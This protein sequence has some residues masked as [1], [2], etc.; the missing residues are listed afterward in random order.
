MLAY[1]SKPELKTAFLAE[2]AKHEQADRIAH[3]G[4]ATFKQ[5]GKPTFSQGCAV[6]CSLESMRIIEG[7][8]SIEHGN[9]ALYEKYLGVPKALARLEDRLFENLPLAD[10]LTWPRRFSEA[11]R[12]GADLSMAMPRFLLDL[13]S[14][15][16]GA[17]QQRC[18]KNEKIA[19]VVEGVAALYRLWVETGTKPS[20]TQ[21]REA[22][23]RSYA[24]YA[25]AA[26]A[27]VVAAYAYAAADAY[28]AVAAYAATDAAA[29][30]ASADE[31][32]SYA[33]AADARASRSQEVVRQADALIRILE[34]M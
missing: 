21:W 32:A 25:D 10:S 27:Y 16:T 24:A 31:A 6:G 19:A 14:D 23:D 11:I 2:I 12:P 5:N 20:A 13:L 33:S 34:A 18:A 22:S 3:V 28:V 1:H 26:Y 7:L 29:S 17:V 30:Y 9:H 8:D 4:Y 15:P